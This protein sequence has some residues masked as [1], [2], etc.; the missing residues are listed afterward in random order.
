MCSKRLRSSDKITPNVVGKLIGLSRVKSKARGF[1]KMLQA[2]SCPQVSLSA[3]RLEKSY[4]EIIAVSILN[5][6]IR[7]IEK[8]WN[9]VPSDGVV[10]DTRS[11]C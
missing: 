8:L 6:L 10:A 11:V 3:K 7:C 1:L 9:F 5:L 2:Q 4:R